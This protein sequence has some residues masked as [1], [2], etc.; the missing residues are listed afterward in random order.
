VTILDV[1]RGAG[2][3][4]TTAS[5][6]LTG[7]GRVSAD[8][9]RQIQAVA[10]E[11]GYTPST[12]ARHLR[13]SRTGALGLHLP[14]MSTGV[15]Y[16]MQFAFGA[17][18]RAR[19]AGY[20]LTLLAPDSGPAGATRPRVDGIVIIDPMTGDPSVA[21]LMAGGP[22]VVTG[23]RSLAPGLRPSGVV[24]ADH[25]AVIS[26]VLDH[27]RDRGA[28]RPALL[29][30]EGTSD[31]AASLRRGFT[32]WCD[33]AD[34]TGKVVTVAFDAPPAEITGATRWLLE[35]APE[36]DAVICAPD[37]AALGVPGAAHVLGRSVGRDL[38]LA[39][40]V[41]SPAMELSMPPI[42]AVDLAPRRF[43]RDCVDLL[44]ELVEERAEPGQIR[45]QDFELRPRASTTGPAS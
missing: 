45:M 24:R 44:V 5:D 31:W 13:G 38:L 12:A 2:V 15:N 7:K 28:R 23:E 9:R 22:L 20:D 21:R 18:A 37:E 19:E 1:A 33:A 42:T 35:S 11:L 25:G 36:I 6:A 32:A 8:T 3:S 40:C 30:P 43:G 34:V 26:A 10:E 29:A 4:K 39:S 16:Y 27:L 41:D 14:Q 17:A